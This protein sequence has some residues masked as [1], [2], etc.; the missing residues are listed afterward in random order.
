[1]EKWS[2]DWQLK[3]NTDKCTVMHLGRNNNASLYVLNDKGLKES[4]SERVLGVIID[5]NLNLSDH[6]N[7]VANNANITLSMF[8]LEGL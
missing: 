8:R 4:E 2:E 1:M 6:C 3:F 5:K 7:K